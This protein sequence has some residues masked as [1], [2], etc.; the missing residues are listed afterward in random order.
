[1]VL[2]V[3]RGPVAAAELVHTSYYYYLL[4]IDA[5]HVVRVTAAEAYDVCT[6]GW[7]SSRCCHEKEAHEKSDA[8]TELDHRHI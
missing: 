2:Q 5:A 8:G 7:Q 6:D 4:R 1:M 3:L